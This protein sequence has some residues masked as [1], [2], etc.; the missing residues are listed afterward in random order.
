MTSSRRESMEEQKEELEATYPVGTL[1]VLEAQEGHTVHPAMDRS[2]PAGDTYVTV[3]TGHSVMTLPGACTRDMTPE[4]IADVEGPRIHC[5]TNHPDY[6][7]THSLNEFAFAKAEA[8]PPS[9][10]VGAFE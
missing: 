3:V 1:V 5:S 2:I 6:Q 7:D 10:I 4:E 9:K 8:S